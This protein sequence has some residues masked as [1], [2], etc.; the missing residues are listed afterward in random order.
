MKRK[1]IDMQ[2]YVERAQNDP[3]FICEMLSGRKPHHIIYQDDR[4]VAF[5][6]KY[7]PLYGYTLVTPRDHR[8]H[9]T[10]DFSL[11]EYLDVQKLIYAV[12]EA[13]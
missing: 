12:A 6:N 5:L 1:H 7:P 8:E 2:R 11:E 10:S 9:V 3:C 13:I 4:H